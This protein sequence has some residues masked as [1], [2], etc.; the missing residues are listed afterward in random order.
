MDA[1]PKRLEEFNR[2]SVIKNLNTWHVT[3]VLAIK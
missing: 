1:V 3:Q 2:I